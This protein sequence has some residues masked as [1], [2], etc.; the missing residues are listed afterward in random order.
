MQ[1]YTKELYQI[2]ID[3]SGIG[4]W[5]WDIDL[6]SLKLSDKMYDILGISQNSKENI[7]DQI[8]NRIHPDDTELMQQFIDGIIENSDGEF[9]LLVRILDKQNKLRYINYVGKLFIKDN[10]R[11]Y[12]GIAYDKTKEKELENDKNESEK[13]LKESE[14]VYKTLVDNASEPIILVDDDHNIILMNDIAKHLFGQ[15]I[16]NN[17]ISLLAANKSTHDIFIEC[18][19]QKDKYF[20]EEV[21]LKTILNNQTHFSM[22]YCP[23][24]INSHFRGGI[25]I[26]YDI[27][28]MIEKEKII[29]NFNR[30]LQQK[31]KELEDFTYIV[32][33]DLKAPL[34]QI[35]MFSDLSNSLL[36]TKE[37]NKC[38]KNLS[39]IID[40]C[41]RMQ[42]LIEDLLELSRIST[43]KNKYLILK[44]SDIISEVKENIEFD[45]TYQNA[46]I[47]IK[48]DID[49]FSDKTQMIQLFQNLISN[50]IKFKKENEELNIYIESNENQIIYSDNGIGFDNKY[51]EKIFEI[52]ER[53]YSKE[54]YEGTGIGLTICKKICEEHGWLISADGKPNEG[55]TF[56]ILLGGPNE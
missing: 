39:K 45:I 13:Q 42:N 32:S 34:R 4:M 16:E 30:K 1:E 19:V 25:F 35:K 48:N 22:S 10:K 14:I 56:T 33:H 17:D 52:F 41:D 40:V 24:K 55:A 3:A 50:S 46:K 36:K 44:L 26:L 31:N 5:V 29:R 11:I 49:L 37:Y 21:V 28:E 38:E 6:H 20:K 7:L 54:K 53:L 18:E 8:K 9:K 51:K 27:S 15:N 12:A 2:A 47:N 23:V 43:N